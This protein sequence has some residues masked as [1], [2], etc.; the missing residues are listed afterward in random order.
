MSSRPP[1]GSRRQRGAYA[2]AFVVFVVVLL[3]FMGL[4]VDAGRLYVSKTE[5]QNAADSCALSA[6]AALTGANANQLEQAEDWGVAAGQR[7]LVGM[8]ETPV[9]IPRDSAI[10]FSETLN[11]TYLAKFAVASGDVL[12][13]RYARCTLQES[14]IKTFLIHVVNLIPG[15]KIG[16]QQVAA[17]AVASNEPS[18]SNCAIPLAICKSTPDHADD[19]A[20]GYRRGEWVTGLY[21][22]G[23]PG[24]QGSYHWVKFPGF[25]KE[26]EIFDLIAGS[27][28]CALSNTSTVETKTGQISDL[29]K[30]WN[31]RFGVW[32]GSGPIGVPDLTG[33]AYTD[34]G[35]NPNWPSGFNAFD[36]F[37]AKRGT[38]TPWNG[39]PQPFTGGWRASSVA[40]HQ[41]GADRRLVVQPIVDCNELESKVT[42]TV[43]D[44]GCSLLLHPIANPT[45]PFKIEYRGLA[46]D[47]KSGCVTSG[48]PGGTTAGGPKVPT[49][50][51]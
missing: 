31:S 14:N 10:T 48:L 47:P 13:M 23:A 51:Q 27:G 28:Q 12:K 24:T 37:K 45:D 9:S 42:T 3:G 7:N 15:Q 26:K 11:G 49:L 30:A 35:D 44:W 20:Y 34:F 46:S 22:P 19:D 39:L 38:L 40:D 6:A 5:L 2:V 41:A 25:E 32:L 1:S 33:Y 18:R 43:V 4:A 21:D 50:V 36:D 29:A 17:T 8:Q 16:L